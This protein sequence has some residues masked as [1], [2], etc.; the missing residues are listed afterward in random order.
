M[1]A[2]RM[3]RRQRTS[4]NLPDVPAFLS[5]LPRTIPRVALILIALLSFC[6]TATPETELVTTIVGTSGRTVGTLSKSFELAPVHGGVLYNLQTKAYGT[7]LGHS[8]GDAGGTGLL[9]EI[10][11]TAPNNE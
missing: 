11:P 7:E 6:A 3:C 1:S 10:F 5:S 9:L 8:T 4:A 2:D